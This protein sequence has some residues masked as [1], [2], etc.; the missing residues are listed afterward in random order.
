[1]IQSDSARR[2]AALLSAFATPEAKKNRLPMVGAVV[3]IDYQDGRFRALVQAMVPQSLLVDGEEWD[4]GMS[5]VFGSVVRS[6]VSG[7]V[8]ILRAG[9]PVILESEM[10]FRPGPFDV[11][12]VGQELRSGGIAS[13]KLRGEWPYLEGLPIVT[14]I[15]VLQPVAG[16]FL[17]DGVRR[18]N[19]SLALGEDGIVQADR[20]A[21]MLSLVCRP[22]DRNKALTVE[23]SVTGEAVVEFP[24][25]EVQ[26]GGETCVQVR[27]VIP[28]DKLGA[29]AFTYTVRVQG[30]KVERSHTFEV[31]EAAE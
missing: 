30:T 26:P 27:D 6:D 28:K 3:P 8:S 31:V 1:V 29:G 21:A 10:D 11:V 7:R 20:P 15:V 5:L 14:N 18:A 25:L 4:L 16:A 9:V 24:S 2:T 19:G 12:L 13:G 22:G 17:R 23:R